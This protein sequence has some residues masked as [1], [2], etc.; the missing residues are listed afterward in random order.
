MTTTSTS[1][2]KLCRREGKKLMLKG[3]RCNSPK[4][5]LSRRSYAPGVHGPKNTRVRHSE[6]SL[7]LR[8]KQRAKRIYG[9][10]E[11]QFKLLFVKASK[12]GNAGSSLMGLL[13][14]RLDNVIYRFG[15]AASRAQARQLVGHCHF[16]INGKTVNIPS[17]QVNP[18]D[19]I[20]VKKSKKNNKIFVNM[21]D[22][23]K[24]TVVPGWLNFDVSEMT[25]KVLHQPSVEDID[26]SVNNQMIVEF[27]SK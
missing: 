23:M 16:L 6:Y 4:C 5:A 25:G 24:K 26:K 15:F 10:R 14:T 2:C 21:A 17:Y 12:G 22:K 18:G 20:S 27:Y 11:K 13:E 8:E 9:M 19:L 3:E 1:K 7:Q